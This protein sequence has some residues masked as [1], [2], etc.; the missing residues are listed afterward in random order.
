MYIVFWKGEFFV[1]Y[2]II[3]DVWDDV[4]DYRIWY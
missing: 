3:D 1:G 2:R 4:Y